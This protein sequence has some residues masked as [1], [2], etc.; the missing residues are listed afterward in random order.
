MTDAR[1]VRSLVEDRPALEP[2]LESLLETDDAHD[3]WTF[4]DTGLDSGAFGELV[5]EGVVEKVDGEYRLADPAAVERAL[6]GE[7]TDADDGDG[8]SLSLPSFD[9]DGRVAAALAG[10]LAL[11]FVFR[12]LTFDAVFRDG[13]V[14]LLGNDPYFYLYW[15]EELSRES[16][17]V[18]DLGAL[19]AGSFG[20]LKSEPLLVAVLWVATELVGG[21]ER[22]P[23]VLAWYPVVAGVVT[24]VFTYLFATGLTDDERV[25]I[26]SVVMLA[27]MPVLAFRSG[28]G[29]AD[30]HAFDYVWLSMTAAAAVRLVRVAPTQEAIANLR[31]ISCASVMGIGI[32]GQL[33]AW[34]AGPLLLIPLVFYVPL[35]ALV[36][37]DRDNSPGLVLT[38]LMSGFVIASLLAGSVHIV[39]DW[40]TNLVAHTPLLLFAG[41]AT[42]IAVG[43]A[44]HRAPELPLSRVRAMVAA[45]GSG[46]IILGFLLAFVFPAYGARVAGQFARIG[47][48]QGIVEAKSL[49]STGTFGWLFL[50]GLLL[51]IGIPYMGWSMVRATR[52]NEPNKWLLSGVYAW[53]FYYLLRF[54]CGSRENSL[55]FS[56]HSPGSALFTSLSASNWL[57][58]RFR[59][60]RRDQSEEMGAGRDRRS[61]YRLQESAWHSSSCSFC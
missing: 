39:F 25:G 15:T 54:R 55:L 5:S 60:V 1:E 44:I 14:V 53:F 4:D 18:L 40:Q 6:A 28:L 35:A 13:R 9:I 7:V 48:R 45:E 19:T 11:V 32:A 51:F 20:L 41:T 10:A 38:P 37:L 27:V 50:F 31:T 26:A 8:V 21:V 17:G 47:T 16:A 58:R 46:A 12:I 30:H 56:Q 36:A 23:L 61:I 49:F 59:S 52:G 24:G 2:A 33:L 22:A 43:E 42:V 3:T 57:A 29:F 34:E